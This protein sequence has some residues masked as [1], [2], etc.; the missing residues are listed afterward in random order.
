M[1][2]THALGGAIAWT[3]VAPLLHAPW[4][5]AVAGVPLAAAAALGPD[6]DHPGSAASRVLPPVARVVGLVTSHRVQTH[7]IA[8]A[9]AVYLAMAPLGAVPAAVACTGWASHVLLDG[10]TKEGVAWFWPLT[11]D[12][13]SLLFWLPRSLRIRT[14][15]MSEKV[16]TGI[17]CLGFVGYEVA[18]SIPG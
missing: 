3:V 1:G 18:R 6:I 14:N 12:K 5:V 16:F 8:S 13:T 4:Q 11:R 9:V 2:T 7:S 10:V 17:M 15:G